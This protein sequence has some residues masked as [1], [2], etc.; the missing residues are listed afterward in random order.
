MKV[1]TRLQSLTLAP[2]ILFLQELFAPKAI[3]GKINEN[4]LIIV[5]ENL[6]QVKLVHKLKKIKWKNLLWTM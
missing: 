6:V 1:T 3:Y 5:Y 4:S 2:F